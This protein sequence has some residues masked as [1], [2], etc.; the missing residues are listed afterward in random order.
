MQC[1]SSKPRAFISPTTGEPSIPPTLAQMLMNP[2][3]TA[4]A[5]ADID[6]V[7]STQNGDGQNCAKKPMPHS[8]TITSQNGCPGTKLLIRQ[9]PA[10]TCP[11]MQCHLRSPVRSDD[12]PEMMTPARPSR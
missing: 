6:I 2:I 11:A 7:G 3:D 12:W 10:P 1:T 9:T 4:A 5:D 8:Q